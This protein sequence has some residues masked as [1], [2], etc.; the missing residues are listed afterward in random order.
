MR[1]FLACREN[2]FLHVLKILDTRGFC[3][4]HKLLV[5]GHAYCSAEPQ[6]HHHY[7][8]GRSITFTLNRS[9]SSQKK[10]NLIGSI[11]LFLLELSE[12]FFYNLILYRY[13]HIMCIFICRFLI[14]DICFPAR[15]VSQTQNAEYLILDMVE[16]GLAITWSSV[17]H[18]LCH[19]PLRR[20]T[21]CDAL[22]KC[23]AEMPMRINKISDDI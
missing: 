9:G 13:M 19:L 3:R 20:R 1:S 18:P 17:V 8:R 7:G 11:S 6:H 5:R 23:L 15:F 22:L 14:R 2:L 10:W 4:L 21:S 16:I 12:S